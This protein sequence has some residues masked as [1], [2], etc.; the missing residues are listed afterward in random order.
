MSYWQSITDTNKEYC[1]D[2]FSGV[3]PSQCEAYGECVEQKWYDYMGGVAGV[4]TGACVNSDDG[5]TTCYENSIY[6]AYQYDCYS[7]I[8]TNTEPPPPPP[9]DPP[10]DPPE[11]VPPLDPHGIVYEH[12]ITTYTCLLI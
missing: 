7:A 9:E 2:H 4:P 8:Y 3:S 10:V 12:C 5:T 6:R 11:Q 1:N